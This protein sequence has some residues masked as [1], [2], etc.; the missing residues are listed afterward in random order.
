MAVMESLVTPQ[1][2]VWHIL[3]VL[4]RTLKRNRAVRMFFDELSDV[5]YDYR[6]RPAAN[7]VGNA[8]QAYH[9]LGIF[10]NGVALHRPA[11]Q[12]EGAAL[13]EHLPRRVLLRREPRR[14]RRH[15]L[16]P[17]R[18]TNGQIVE[19]YGERA[20]DD[21]KEKAKNPQ[22]RDQKREVLHV[23]LPNADYVP[24]P[25]SAPR[26]SSSCRCTSTCSRRR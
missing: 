13:Q 1:N 24:A 14:H 10:G 26:R 15:A 22:Q 23:V 8:Q 25:C 17:F 9:S 2:S 16:S 20:P 19:R 18:L 4:D 5:L 6:Y 3:K 21:V 11:R 12:R 7:F